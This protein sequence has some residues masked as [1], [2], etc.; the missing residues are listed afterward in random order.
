MISPELLRRFSL[1]SGL[2]P[3]VFSELAMMGDTRTL[4]SGEWLFEA[5]DPADALYLILS[6][7]IELH[8]LLNKEQQLYQQIVSLVQGEAVGWEALVEP[9]Q[10]TTGAAATE[11][12]ELIALDAASLRAFMRRHPA[13]GLVIMTRTA[14]MLSRQLDQLQVRFASLFTA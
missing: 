8:V 7:Q 4:Q 11:P 2:E 9:H 5:Q 13:V 12:T 3:A 6:G 14:Q 1:F 10:H